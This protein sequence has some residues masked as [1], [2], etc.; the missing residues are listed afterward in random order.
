[1][2]AVWKVATP[3]EGEKKRVPVQSRILGRPETDQNSLLPASLTDKK[4]HANRDAP[5]IL[6]PRSS[7]ADGFRRSTRPV[8][9]PAGENAGSTVG[10]GGAES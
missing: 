3:E 1:M 5:D 6:F 8:G 7:R 9:R 4:V 2:R 10:R